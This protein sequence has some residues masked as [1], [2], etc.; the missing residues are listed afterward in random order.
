MREALGDLGFSLQPV[1]DVP[2]RLETAVRRAV[3]RRLR[4]LPIRI[5]HI[6]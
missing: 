2:A 1:L 5:E 3:I 4:D 6:I